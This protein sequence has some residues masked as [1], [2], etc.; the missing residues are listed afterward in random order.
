[1]PIDQHPETFG[2]AVERYLLPVLPVEM[3]DATAS[4]SPYPASPIHDEIRYGAGR[5]AIS[6]GKTREMTGLEKANA[7]DPLPWAA[8]A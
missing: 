2:V 4:G 3:S 7:A 5:E 1:M 8:A 6:L